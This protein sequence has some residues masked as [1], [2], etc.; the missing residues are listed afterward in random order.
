MLFT[1]LSRELLSFE[2]FF[3][4]LFNNRHDNDGR[5]VTLI[6]RAQHADTNRYESSLLSPTYQP[7]TFQKK[8]FVQLNF[9]HAFESR[10]KVSPRRKQHFEFG[11]RNFC[12]EC[13]VSDG[14][15]KVYNWG[16]GAYSCEAKGNFTYK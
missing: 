12:I 13:L 5:V 7:T 15:R 11:E 14:K 10:R 3:N 8:L 16:M 4:L 6:N 1:S 2:L 9:A